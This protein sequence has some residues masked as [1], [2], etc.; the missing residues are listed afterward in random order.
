MGELHIDLHKKAAQLLK[1]RREHKDITA[2]AYDDFIDTVQGFR[3]ALQDLQ[4]TLVSKVCA[5]DHLTGVWNRYAMSH[6]LNQEHE[7]VRRNGE[8]CVIAIMDFDH[9]KNINDRFGHI[10]G[11][12]VLKVVMNHLSH[13]IRQYDVIFR[14]GGEE[15][16]F[17][18]PNTELDEATEILE[19]LRSNIKQL[20][21]E[22]D[23]D[24]IHVTVSIGV[25]AMEAEINVHDTIELA[26]NALL[27]AKMSGRDCV[28]VCY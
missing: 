19:R 21:I 15:F 3:M 2:E 11:D 26:D 22:M 14:Y 17:L 28:Q 18:L 1:L 27:T 8:H 24:T 4:L 16:L 20:P 12:K 9:F 6:R 7:R 13:Q 23:G 25:A 10:A 5:V